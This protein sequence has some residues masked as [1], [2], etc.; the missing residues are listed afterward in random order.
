[1]GE[2]GGNEP[3]YPELLARRFNENKDFEYLINSNM[4]A[5]ND[6]FAGKFIGKSVPNTGIS[7]KGSIGAKYTSL[8]RRFSL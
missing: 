6:F 4:P 8:A 5:A 3:L 2:R 7:L 1:V